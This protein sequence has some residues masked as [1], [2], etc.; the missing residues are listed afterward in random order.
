MAKALSIV[1]VTLNGVD[2]LTMPE[3]DFSPGGVTRT[4]MIASGKRRGTV[5]EPVG[6]KVTGKFLYLS[7]TDVLAIK[8]FDEGQC[9]VITDVGDVW[10]IPNASVMIPPGITAGSGGGIAFEIEGDEAALVSGS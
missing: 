4:S 2:H 8:N 3:V 9:Q 7:T 6:S 10:D 5:S 1:K